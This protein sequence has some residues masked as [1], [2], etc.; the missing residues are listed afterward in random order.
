MDNKEILKQFNEISKNLMSRCSPDSDI[1]PL[2]TAL[3]SLFNLVINITQSL[4]ENFESQINFFKEQAQ[5]SEEENKNL[6]LMIKELQEQ[7]SNS[8]ITNV[9]LAYEAINGKGSEKN[10]PN[11]EAESTQPV[12]EDNDGKIFENSSNPDF[13]KDVNGDGETPK[14]KKSRGKKIP[15]NIAETRVV[16]VD[17][18]GNKM[19]MEEAKKLLNTVVEKDGK[20]YKCVR[21][22]ESTTKY[23]VETKVVEIK[24]YKTAL[25]EVDEAGRP[26][27]GNHTF[28]PA[29]PETDFMKK[30]KIS[31]II[32]SLIL[33]MWFG[34]RLP[35]YRISDYLAEKYGLMIN[36]KDIYRYIDIVSAMLMP[37]FQRMQRESISKALLIGLDETFWKVRQKFGT[38]IG[39]QDE[40]PPEVLEEL[41]DIDKADFKT[42]KSTR[43][44]IFAIVTEYGCMYY[45]SVTHAPDFIKKIL[46]ENGIN[47][48]AFVAC[49]GYYKKSFFTVVNENGELT[50]DCIEFICEYGLCWIHVKRYWC[51]CFNFLCNYNPKDGSIVPKRRAVK[52][53][54]EQDVYDSKM[55]M[56]KISACFHANNQISYQLLDNP[57]LD[58]V[59]LRKEKVEPLLDDLFNTARPVYEDVIAWK[60]E[61]KN[62][63]EIPEGRRTYS[64]RF[65]DA[66]EYLINNEQALRTFINNKNGV[67]HNNMTEQKFR[68]LDI[69]RNSMLSNE[70]VKGAE[71]LALMYSFYQ[72][73]KLHGVNFEEYMKKVLAVMTLNM[74]KIIF[75]K[76]KNGTITGFKSHTISNEVLDE[77][78]P[79][80][81]NFEK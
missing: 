78:M 80:N 79:W 20:F 11:T 24:Y 25:V 13:D 40:P 75:E 35:V 41:D 68:P 3:I 44:F 23:E 18:F 37:V 52:A 66:I 17:I 30:N 39:K 67:M 21:I 1:Y 61:K 47:P 32:M 59:A 56:D 29:H 6:K 31:I 28:V 34:L 72:S 77:L 55:F 10:K 14:K 57:E 76:N 51:S 69:L 22:D 45:H 60:N 8:T 71:N 50:D 43:T 48:E 62:K 65:C 9:K 7:L 2:V 64:K 49:D 15:S 27:N 19:T 74:N 63:K 58:V 33:S 81:E 70:T 54:W 73:C 42:K 53:K 4:K 38:G 5:K 16:V 12:D 26:V 46:I 36:R